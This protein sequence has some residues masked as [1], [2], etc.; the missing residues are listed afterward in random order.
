M[1]AKYTDCVTPDFDIACAPYAPIDEP[2][3]FNL[4]FQLVASLQVIGQEFAFLRLMFA[5]CEIQIADENNW[6]INR[7]Y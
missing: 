2:F 6:K 1:S 3:G 7:D 5:S 4:E